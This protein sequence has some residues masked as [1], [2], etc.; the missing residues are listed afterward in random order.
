[1]QPIDLRSDTVTKPSEGMREAMAYA[2]VGD[3][4]YGEDPT[5]NRLQEA[6]A[7]LLGKEAAL[8]VPSGT[9]SNQVAIGALT[10]PGDEVICDANAHVAGF[11]AGGL[12][13]LWGVQPRALPALRGLL[14]PAAVEA[15]IRPA[16]EHYPRPSVLTVEQT[17]NRGGGAVYPLD[18]L[19]DLATVALR[20]GL[21][22][23]MDGARLWNACAATELAP[24]EF[25]VHATTVSVC[26][27][28]GLGAPVGSVVAGPRHVISEARR[29]RRRLGG[30]MRQAGVL[31]AAG[32]YALEHNRARLTDDHANARLLAERLARIPG[33]TLLHPVETNLVFVAFA[34]RDA[35]D[36][37]RTL[38]AAGVLANPEGSRPDAL[39]FVTHL[40]VKRDEITVA[41]E[42]ITRALNP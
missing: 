27:S 4:V 36:V 18:Q 5:V 1:M 34:D 29:L 23:H 37:S 2:E 3:D 31:A 10:R 25:A 7:A 32:L 39:R 33:A 8:F 14:D 19:R 9:M 15:A 20:H 26:L 13:A 6:V 40:D 30:G 24:S 42:R 41:A 38:A 35:R 21:A 12:A 17:H 28:K 16:S 11:E 22:I